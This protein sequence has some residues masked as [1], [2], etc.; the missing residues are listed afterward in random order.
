MEIIKSDG[1]RVAFRK[2][3]IASSI[4][5]AGGS[6]EFAREV[7]GRVSRKVHSGATTEKIL[8]LTLKN[9]KGKKAVAARYNLKKAIMELGPSGFTFEEYVSLVLQAYG[10]ETITSAHIRGKVILQEIDVIAR[11]SWKTSMIEA[12]YHNS[13]G[14]RTNTKV[15]MYTHARFLDV[16]SNKKNSFDDAWLVTNTALTHSARDY[17]RGVKLRVISWDY[18]SVGKTLREMIEA[19]KLYPIT[20]FTCVS[21]KT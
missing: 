12:K 2:S 7:A 6:R 8:D 19:E 20:I 3:K 1:R 16:V 13:R 11:K 9:L 5:R 10:Y 14:I 15:A 21:K 17:S 4:V 18:S